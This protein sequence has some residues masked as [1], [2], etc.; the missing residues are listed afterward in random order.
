MC[1]GSVREWGE[2]NVFHFLIP[3]FS[4]SC[5]FFKIVLEKRDGINMLSCHEW[6]K[7]LETGLA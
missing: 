2:D 4:C 3:K 7:Y 1:V 6:R 5:L